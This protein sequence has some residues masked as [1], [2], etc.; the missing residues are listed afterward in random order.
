[1]LDGV[2]VVATPKA[3]GLVHRVAVPHKEGMP[4]RGSVLSPA[5]DVQ[6][7]LPS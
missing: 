4:D 6:V 3:V 5:L 7:V 1:M 2:L